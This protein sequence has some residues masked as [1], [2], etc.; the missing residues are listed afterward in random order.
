MARVAPKLVIHPHNQLTLTA[1]TGLG[2]STTNIEYISD[3]NFYQFYQTIFANY[4]IDLNLGASYPI[5]DRLAIAAEIIY[6]LLT[7]ETSY[8]ELPALVENFNC[9]LLFSLRYTFKHISTK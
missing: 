4:Q 1:G 2:I 5:T 7:Y 9:Q 8:S 6:A 3:K